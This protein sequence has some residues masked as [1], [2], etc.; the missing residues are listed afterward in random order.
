M[1]E[2]LEITVLLS[3][4]AADE[5]PF[6]RIDSEFFRKEF[7]AIP[8]FP[9]RL[10]DIAII[11]S[12]TTPIDR[13]DELR[14]GVV[15]LK[16]A[17]IRNS[18][19]TPNNTE[20]YYIKPDIAA[21]MSKTMLHC[22]DVLI[23]IVGATTDVIGR[24]GLV[25]DGFPEANITQAMALIRITDDIFQPSAVFAFLAGKF[26]Q[27]QVRKLARPTGQYNL[28]LQEVS[29]IAIPIFSHTFN[30]AIN[31]LV[32]NAHKYMMHR[33][34]SIKEADKLFIGAIGLVNWQP[35]EPLTYTR[36]A[37]ETFDAERLDAEHFQ[38]KF[39]ALLN[40]IRKACPD[41]ASLCEVILP[42]KNGYD[43][44]DFTD[45]GTPYIRVGDISGC[46][47]NLENASRVPINIKQVSKNIELKIGDVLFTRKG[48]F[49][50]AAPVRAGDEHAI[51][52]S[53]IMLIRLRDEAKNKI[54][55]EYL[56]MFF[57]S[58]AGQYQAEQ[59][60][61]GAAFYSV[62]QD[63][64]DR[65]II[66]ILPQKIQE[67][68]IEKLHQSETARQKA[69]NL[70]YVAKRSVEIAIEKSEEKAIEFLESKIK[71]DEQND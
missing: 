50:N 51:I 53:E 8:K 42:V 31:L 21:R 64:L 9:R 35:P 17:D 15:L 34:F 11:R 13:D 29:S 52:S 40:Q 56:A 7:N 22:E 27:L 5:N 61:H 4:A 60:A 70:L 36:R 33:N 54:A 69:Y 24:V 6:F 68:L 63:D 57:N 62:A 47:I 45:A 18:V 43:F 12:G 39:K 32:K 49:G 2:G 14:T 30:Y 46:R 66:P 16:T 41:H 28:N 19:L 65:F 38:P 71:E 44:R 67:D 48:S 10:G 3:S 59:W 58:L 23:N 26:G 37:S 25:P 55:P 1:L 20:Y